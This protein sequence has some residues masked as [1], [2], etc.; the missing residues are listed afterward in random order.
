MGRDE[1]GEEEARGRGIVTATCGGTDEVG[2]SETR[3]GRRGRHRVWRV[4]SMARCRRRRVWR[5][6]RW[7]TA[8]RG[9]I[10]GARRRRH[11]VWRDGGG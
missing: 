1:A 4:E 5:V 8:M 6:E 2:E 10:A 7:V 3:A 9:L 11:C